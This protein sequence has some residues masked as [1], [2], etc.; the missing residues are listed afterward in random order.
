MIRLE[1]KARGSFPKEL[2]TL[3]PQERN[4]KVRRRRKDKTLVFTCKGNTKN[5]D[6]QTAEGL[7]YLIQV[8]FYINADWKNNSYNRSISD[9][10]A[11]VMAYKTTKMI[12]GLE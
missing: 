12:L 11:Q 8:G 5:I 1:M 7:E 3:F 10:V 4:A 6:S 9:L 2:L